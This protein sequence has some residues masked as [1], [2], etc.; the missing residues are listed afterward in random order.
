MHR[1]EFVLLTDRAIVAI[2]G[3][4][5]VGFLQGLATNDITRA[6]PDQAIYAALLTPQGRYV[7]DFCV[8]A[9]GE[10]LLLDCEAARRD[11]LLRRLKPYKLRS[12]VDLSDAS[13]RFVVVA[14]IGPDA[15]TTL[16]LPAEPGRARPFGD[17][18]A[19]TDP[20][21][22]DLGARAIL[23]RRDDLA[24]VLAAEGWHATEPQAYERLRLGL[25]IPDGSRDMAIEKALL[26]E[27]NIDV[28]NGISWTK[29][30][31]LGQE[32]TA[33][34]RY[35]ALV[36]KRLTPVSLNGALPAPGTPILAGSQ[37]IGEIRSGHGDHALALLRLEETARA[38]SDAVTLIAD[39]TEI[40]PNRPD[41]FPPPA[42]APDAG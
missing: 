5:R 39:G 40:T 33:R 38:L 23:P 36:R 3:T 31:Y 22:A 8:A 4:D 24:A 34:T 32:V 15:L 19:F 42:P 10:E 18:I 14:L 28:L 30:C 35:R 17:G 1:N 25:G 9:P 21:L 37:E 27:N 20:R 6:G 12:K 13:D 7:H 2:G 26:L 16:G 29:G 11:D 41:W